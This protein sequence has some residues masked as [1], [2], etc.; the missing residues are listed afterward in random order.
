MAFFRDMVPGNPRETGPTASGPTPTPREPAKPVDSPPRAAEKTEATPPPRTLIR[1]E[2]AETRPAAAPAAS[3]SRED[4]TESVIGPQLTLEGKIEG[5]GHVRIAGRFK[6]DVNVQGN[7][8]IERGAQVSG[9]VRAKQVVVAGTLDG[10]IDGAERVELQKTAV[11][12]GDLKAASLVVAGG[13][14]MRGQVEFGWD[15]APAGR[16]ATPLRVEPGG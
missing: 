10:N 5:V 6:G 3:E 15:E 11:L 12:T 2:P 8:T 9:Q 13:S 7:L 16:S 14:R 1:P 4:A